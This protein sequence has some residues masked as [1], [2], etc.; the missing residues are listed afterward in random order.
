M[1]RIHVGGQ[2]FSD[3]VGSRIGV[4]KCILFKYG[5]GTGGDM[6]LKQFLSSTVE[7]THSIY[8]STHETEGELLSSVRELG[9]PPDLEL[10]SLL[11]DLTDGLDDVVKKDRF[12]TDG[13]MVTDLLE[14]SSN[15]QLGRN[16]RDG[17]KKVLAQVSSVAQKQI[18][19]FKLVLDSVMDLVRKT[20]LDEVEDRIQILKKVVKEK[21][22]IAILAVP[23]G[24]EGLKDIETTLFDAIITV[25]ADKSSGAWKRTVTLENLKGSS[26]PPTEWELGHLRN[27]QTAKSLK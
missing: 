7:G 27:I 12:R 14:V 23:L 1:M 4:G 8:L 20:S 19:P 5:P 2:E 17:V 21:E 18:L 26:I 10:I 25:R 22:G 24:F 11:P 13:I 16:R 6:L 9:L 15:T 3:L